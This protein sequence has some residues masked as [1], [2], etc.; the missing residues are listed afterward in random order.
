MFELRIAK[1]LNRELGRS[2]VYFNFTGG[3]PGGGHHKGI[4]RRTGQ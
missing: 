3:C 2:L 1:E 4:D